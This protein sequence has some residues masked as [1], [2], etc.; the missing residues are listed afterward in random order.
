MNTAINN[1]WQ[2]T[3]WK[4]L[5]I[6]G[7]SGSGKTEVARQLG[8][9]LG[10]PWLQVDDLRLAFQHSQVALPQQQATR[11]LYFF[12]ETSHI[13]QL[14]AETL[15]DGL[16]ASSRALIP[17]L[18]IVIANHIDTDAPL[19]I[20]GD[21]ILP[22]LVER[23]LLQRYTDKG[24]IHTVF[25]YESEAARLQANIEARAREQ[26]ISQRKNCKQKPTPSGC[27]ASG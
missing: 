25:L 10:L 3:D 24:Q 26:H 2:R 9:R 7:S 19:I 27:T 23:P 5:L 20:E 17:A 8:L 16:I 1:R 13:W 4:V 6:G 11:D 12:A 21:N 18:E 14:A 22:E 15:C